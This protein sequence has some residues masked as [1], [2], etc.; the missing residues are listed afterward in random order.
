MNWKAVHRWLGLSL[1]TVA[2]VLGLSGALLALDPVQ[3][4]W[5]APTAPADL[6]VA[7]LVQQV[8]QAMPGVEEIRRLPSGAVAANS[9]L[10]ATLEAWGRE[11]VVEV[12][13]PEPFFTTDNAAM[14]ALAGLLR[15]RRHGPEPAAAAQ[16]RSRWPLG[17]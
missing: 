2:L 12:L 13:L 9:E 7:T 17:S 6:P 14:I 11:R 16:A 1:G 10:R 4:A 5:Q 15:Y 3:E 8:Q